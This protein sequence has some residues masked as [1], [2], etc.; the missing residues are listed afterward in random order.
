MTP[1]VVD[2]QGR[3]VSSQ[4]PVS[5]I[6]TLGRLARP[7]LRRALSD[8]LVKADDTLFD[9][10]QSSTGTSETQAL[11][12]AMR[13]I[14]LNRMA[15]EGE[16]DR[17]LSSSL[18]ALELGSP[19]VAGEQRSKKSE[20]SLVGED[21]LEEQLGSQTL[22][23]NLARRTGNDYEEFTG[24]LASMCSGVE[25]TSRHNPLGPEHIAEA[26]R[27]G[28]KQIDIS[29][30]VR[31]ILFKLIERG[32]AVIMG[33]LHGELNRIL[34]DAGIR[35]RGG[36]TAPRPAP[37]PA[38][39][40]DAGEGGGGGGRGGAGGDGDAD[41][42]S[43]EDVEMVR[44][45]Q[46]LLRQHRGE[47]AGPAPLP[48]GAVPMAQQEMLSVLSLYQAQPPEGLVAALSDPGQSLADKLKREL[49]AGAIRMGVSP[50]NARMKPGDEDTLDLVGML[51][52]VLLSER[53][54]QDKM[55]GTLS[56]LVVP[57]AKAALI[58]RRMFLQ[59]SHPARKLLNS[60]AEA[61]ESITGESPQDREVQ[62]KVEGTVD[63][64]VAEFNEDVAIFQEL[65]QE[66]RNYIDQYR[67][68]VELAERRA[69]EAQRGKERLDQ[70]RALAS[71]ELAVRLGQLEPPP[72][73]GEILRR[74]WVH[75]LTVIWLRQGDT[76]EAYRQAIAAGE[77]VIQ[78]VV[79]A[80]GGPQ[81]LA[82][83]LDDMRKSLRAILA[84]SGVTG[85]TAD[86]T[87]EA[88]ESTLNALSAGAQVPELPEHIAAAAHLFRDEAKAEEQLEQVASEPQGAA[89]VRLEEDFVTID[90]DQMKQI[91][92]LEQG[93][94]IELVDDQGRAEPAKLSWVSPISNRRLFV[95]RRGLKVACAS[96]D[97]LATMMASGR[98]CIRKADS[99]F[100]RAMHQVLGKLQEESGKPAAH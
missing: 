76:S 44:T 48:P 54:L 40:A 35:S 52:E 59:K 90:P 65:E 60:L 100:E 2:M 14:R 53:V 11:I 46:Q 72:L 77:D 73:M 20:L 69:A 22:A 51:F 71:A 74:Y 67:K 85:E 5:L 3:P 61:S 39:R 30:R 19:E 24:R 8:V 99:A 94:W 34:A 70:A 58:D 13:L 57:Y 84:S 95:N 26:V 23:E 10:M 27:N 43:A 17:S 91:E 98:M 83:K 87:V 29:V 55:R 41:A 64:L 96:V 81:R 15:I 33:P 86:Q 47:K 4:Q 7:K 38:P 79:L 80:K 92:S 82:P 9:L 1:N 66:F 6:G 62:Q 42:L 63:R 97:E 68:R 89:E 49:M 18:A 75:H 50:E 45:L 56:R 78:S 25:F 93:D 12:D 32:I 16:F 37:A 88:V 28:L 31:L 36:T 21:D